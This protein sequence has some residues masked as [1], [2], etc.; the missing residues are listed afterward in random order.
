[1]AC[2][3]GHRPKKQKHVSALNV[4]VVD[5][6]WRDL[7]TTNRG[8]AWDAKNPNFGFLFSFRPNN[9]IYTKSELK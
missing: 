6:P 5:P 1:V 4:A 8:G 2:L 9:G 7:K 3:L